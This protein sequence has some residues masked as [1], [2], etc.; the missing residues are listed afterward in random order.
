MAEEKLDATFF[1]FK[2]RDQRLV[3][4]RA[5][6]AYLGLY[7]VC[8]AV[9]AIAAWSSFAAAYGWYMSAVMATVEGG[10]PSPPPPELLTLVPIGGVATLVFL[11]LFAAFEA[12]SLRWLVRGERGGGLLGL[13]FDGDTWR[14]FAVY[15]VWLFI[16]L[17]IVL[18]IAVFYVALQAFGSLGGP[19]QLV[20]M[21]IGGLAP[22][23]LLALWILVA[24]RLAPAAANSM[25]QQRFAFFGAWRVT[26]G[27]FWPLLG[28]Y[29]IVMVGYFVVA[30]VVGEIVQMPINS[31]MTPIMQDIMMGGDT[32][33]AIQ[34][35]TAA[36]QTPTFLIFGSLYMIAAAIIATVYYVAMFGI[37]ARVVLAAVEEGKITPAA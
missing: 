37:N 17:A 15:W 6:A 33:A 22:L 36:M 13:K 18:A 1:A 5:S 7:L 12:A 2:K 8:C 24:V 31:V 20:A 35:M 23:G 19:M 27:H 25:A 21:I 14:V 16:S 9:Y 3:L 11:I 4:T 10:E 29:L 30:I 28:S 32:D 34:N 26:R